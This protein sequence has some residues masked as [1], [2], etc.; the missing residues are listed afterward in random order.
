M[1]ALNF[2]TQKIEFERM[3]SKNKEI[4]TIKVDPK[5]KVSVLAPLNLEEDE[6]TQIMKKKA[7]WIIDKFQRIDE[8]Q[9]LYNK[10]EFVS[11]ESFFYKGKLLRLKIKQLKNPQEDE[12][13]TDTTTIFCKTSK[14]KNPEHL[15]K[16]IQEWYME[17][18]KN[19]L[20]N[21]LPRLTKKFKTKPRKIGI[22]NQLM[23][24]GS[25]TKNGDILINWKIMMAPPSVIDYVV[26]HELAHLQE[27]NHSDKFWEGVKNAIPN[28]E[29][30]K[31]WLRVNG[32]KLTI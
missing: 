19:Y 10:H 3:P 22:R 14:H 1:A 26:V 9:I 29:E 8:I 6:L 25:C 21:R 7:T 30:K 32:P 31:E 20:N 18:A 5:K 12:I 2:G 27:K 15:K 4:I 16:I 11:G 24:W 13:F 17:K 23:R 28:Y